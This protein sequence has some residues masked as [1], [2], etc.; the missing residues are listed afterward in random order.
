MEKINNK[1]QFAREEILNRYFMAYRPIWY[2]ISTQYDQISVDKSITEVDATTVVNLYSYRINMFLGA[3]CSNSNELD[4]EEVKDL[5]LSGKRYSK[6]NLKKLNIGYDFDKVPE[7]DLSNND[8]GKYNF[9]W[10][11]GKFLFE[12]Y[13]NV[14]SY[15]YPSFAYELKEAREEDEAEFE[16]YSVF[17]GEATEYVFE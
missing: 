5:F 11:F 10:D 8:F 3:N 4:F 12:I 2:V 7:I 15:V 13:K 1:V 14:Y 17:S 9:V 6:E 16:V